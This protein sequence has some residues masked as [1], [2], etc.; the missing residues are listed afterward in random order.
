MAE[1]TV[2]QALTQYDGKH[3]GQRMERLFADILQELLPGATFRTEVQSNS[4]RP[5]ILAE[6]LGRTWIFEVK[7]STDEGL[8]PPSAYSELKQQLERYRHWYATGREALILITNYRL[9]PTMEERFKESRLAVFRFGLDQAI[10]VVKQQLR[11]FVKQT[12]WAS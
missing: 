11:D 2:R 7:A 1:T 9:T 12:H 5:D 3:S 6:D 4:L 10:P 8:L